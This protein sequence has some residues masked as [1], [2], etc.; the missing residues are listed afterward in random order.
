MSFINA[1]VG[2]MVRAKSDNDLGLIQTLPTE[3]DA[4]Y[5]VRYDYQHRTK[6]Y[7]V[8]QVEAGA[9]RL[10]TRYTP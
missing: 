9:L 3:T 10:L 1:K 5:T 4:S 7:T 2:D 8:E 6:R